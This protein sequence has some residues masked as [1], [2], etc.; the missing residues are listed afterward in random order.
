MRTAP[1]RGSLAQQEEDR[2]TKSKEAECLQ[3]M[4]W[5]HTEPCV[6]RSSG[7]CW[8]R[9]LAMSRAGYLNFRS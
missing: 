5:R 1:G 7:V 8:L 4:P 9:G 2:L 3:L 6:I